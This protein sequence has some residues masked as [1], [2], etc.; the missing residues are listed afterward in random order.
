MEQVFIFSKEELEE[1][2]ENA[3]VRALERFSINRKNVY[4]SR[5]EV[6]RRLGVDKS[7]LWRWDRDGYLKATRI[8]AKCVYAEDLIINCESGGKTA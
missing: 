7:T 5:D 6:A 3:A 4:L 8:G 1:L 2:L